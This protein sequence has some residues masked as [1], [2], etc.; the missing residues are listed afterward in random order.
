MR[1]GLTWAVAV[2]ISLLVFT[3]PTMATWS[4]TAV[5][6][7]TKQVGVAGA[8]CTFNVQGIAEFVPGKG[9][10]VV[11]AMSS[12]DARTLGFELMDQGK[13]AEEILAAMR[14]PKF[15]PEKQQY[16]VVLLDPE[17]KPS[18]YS[19]KQ[20]SGWSG[21]VT[22]PGVVVAGNILASKKVV[23]DALAAFKK[24]SKKDLKRRL[25]AALVAGADAG[26]D[27]RCADQRARS[28]F[29]G[30]FN[31]GDRQRRPYFFF[32]VYGAEEGGENAV[33]RIEKEVELFLKRGVDP[34]SARLSI[35]P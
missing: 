28:A 16:A 33:E 24:S 7:E 15:D 17:Q 35:V 13:S 27:K 6:F 1:T 21:A 30:V 29:I 34:S 8:S 4:I 22:A 12:K 31:E 18:T 2:A 19:G 5:D 32:M 20:T 25:L 10:L 26:G 3:T 23:D 9:V 11:Q 14:D